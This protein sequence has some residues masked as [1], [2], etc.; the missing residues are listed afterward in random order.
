M[1]LTKGWGA[2]EKV[3]LTIDSACDLPD[4]FSERYTD[5]EVVPLHIILGDDS[6]E[7]GINITSS[8]VIHYVDKTN[9]LP[10]T[11]SMASWEYTEVFTR[12]TSLGLSVVHLSLSSKISASYQNALI[13]SRDFDNVYVVDSLH[14]SSSMALLL[15]KACKMR[16]NGLSAEKIAAGLEKIKHNAITSLI[17]DK[18]DY[19]YKGGRCSALSV[20]GAN[21]LHIKVCVES[22][23][24]SLY[25]KK[26]YRGQLLKCQQSYI[27]DMLTE[28]SGNI[29]RSAAILGYTAGLSPKN[30]AILIDRIKKNYDFKEI[31]VAHPGCTITSHCGPDTLAVFFMTE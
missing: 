5:Y 9:T 4:G 27:D 31:F 7:D 14:L 8:D 10:K 30:E 6:F 13:A 1:E 26:K 21:A 29:D 20:F 3:F 2:M 12:L 11:A 18:L 16:D 23:E 15:M 19:L 24:G 28:H 22:R 17:V 25:V